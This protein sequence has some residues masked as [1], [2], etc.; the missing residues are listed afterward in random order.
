METET[1]QKSNDVEMS[2]KHSEMVTYEK[3]ERYRE[4]E[5]KGSSLEGSTNVK[6][7][8]HHEKVGNRM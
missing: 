2:G 7:M 6:Q 3:P 5:I 1:N 4:L 8:E